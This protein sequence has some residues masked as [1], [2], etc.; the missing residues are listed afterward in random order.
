MASPA[1]HPTFVVHNAVA[2]NMSAVV[3]LEEAEPAGAQVHAL[4]CLPLG[5]WNVRIGAF[6]DHLL[7]LD[8][9]GRRV[10]FVS[11]R[12]LVDLARD[13]GACSA[14]VARITRSVPLR[15]GKVPY[16]GVLHG[17]RLYVDYFLD[18]LVEIYDC[19]TTPDGPT[20][21]FVD[22]LRL[23]HS[24]PLGFSDM[25][26]YQE[27]LVVAAAGI[28][29]FERVCPPDAT[30]DPRVYFMPLR[31]TRPWLPS[32]ELEPVVPS[33]ANSSGLYLHEPT[34]DLYVINS[35][36]YRGGYS[37]L[38]RVL[39]G[40]QLGPE[41]RF[42]A[43]SGAARAFAL[44][45]G[46]FLV[47]QFSGEHVFLVDARGDRLL[48]VRRFRAGS[49]EPVDSEA[50]IPERSAADL[51]DV[52]AD[53]RSAGRFYLVD[54]RGERLVHVAWRPPDALDVIGQV[55]LKTPAFRSGPSWGLSLS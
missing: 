2:G 21:S 5:R 19:A 8:T 46:T 45:P 35:G 28:T 53:P 4:P 55:D 42:P 22:V 11:L 37:S 36:N 40:N 12:E 16:R 18:N 33:N 47:S 41:I 25:I 44:D 32:S 51:Q 34:S 30:S 23:E 7:T 52:I 20:L 50:P 43:G 39:P 1:A 17:S 48:G 29:C 38:Q 31:G 14:D 54:S 27:H 13:P 49:F 24:R 9:D 6:D 15:A 26:V 3:G 10:H